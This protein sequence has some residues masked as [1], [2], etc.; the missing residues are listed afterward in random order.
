MFSEPR[1]LG[2]SVIGHPTR[3]DPKSGRKVAVY[4][5]SCKCLFISSKVHVYRLDDALWPIQSPGLPVPNIP[6]MKM[7]VQGLAI[8]FSVPPHSHGTGFELNVL[9]GAK[10]LLGA[11][12]IKKI[13]TEVGAKLIS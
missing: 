10:R 4:L 9:R 7:D 3:A 2:N 12:A 6:V 5:L 1:N 11:K 8:Q 13:L